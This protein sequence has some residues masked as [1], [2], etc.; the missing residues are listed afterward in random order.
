[1]P[2]A[3]TVE[4]SQ[5]TCREMKDID[6]K[7]VF[8]CNHCSWKAKGNVA[9]LPEYLQVHHRRTYEQLAASVDS[10]TSSSAAS[11]S[12]VSHAPTPSSSPSPRLPS[13]LRSQVAQWCRSERQTGRQ[14]KPYY[15]NYRLLQIGPV[16]YAILFLQCYTQSS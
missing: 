3:R 10:S 9:H 8:R 7:S 6:L 16:N 13:W 15:V 2:P 1:M 11:S 4:W 14:R 5:F 12:S